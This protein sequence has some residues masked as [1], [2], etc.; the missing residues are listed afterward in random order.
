MIPYMIGKLAPN[1]THFTRRCG[2]NV[3]GRGYFHAVPSQ[4][5]DKI[6]TSPPPPPQSLNDLKGSQ[7][8]QDGSCSRDIDNRPG[9]SRSSSSE[10]PKVVS[11][12]AVSQE[13]SSR[14]R[15]QK[16][17]TPWGPMVI[18]AA[19]AV[20]PVPWWDVVAECSRNNKRYAG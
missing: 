14:T 18:S 20:I 7:Q 2:K 19:F 12:T 10:K 3:P 15:A 6:A 11:A 8:S 9:K 17:E 1:S 13:P 16:V 4:N 5:G